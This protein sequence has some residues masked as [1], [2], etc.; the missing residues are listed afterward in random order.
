MLKKVVVV[1]VVLTLGPAVAQTP[2]VVKHVDVYKEDGH[3]AGWPA[4]NGIWAWGDE[5]VVGFSLGYYK[6]HPTGGHAID[7]DRRLGVRQARSLDG[8]ETWS[9]ERPSY[10]GEEGQEPQPVE[11]TGGIDFSNPGFAMRFR[12]D[13]YYYS[14][15]RCKTWEGPFS[16]PKFGRPGLLARTDYLVEDKDT[17]TAFV[18]ATKDNGNE[19]QPLCIRT[20]DGGKTWDLVG[21]IGQQPPEGY[22]YAI[23]PSTIRLDSGAYLSMIR[24]AGVFDGTSRR[25]LEAFLS[26]DR[27]STWYMLDEP[28]IDNG[29]NPAS[30]INLQDGRIVLT[31]GWRRPPR[32]IR[33]LVSED[34]GQTWGPEI[35]LRHDAASWDIGYPR[36]VQ[37]TDG[38]CLT[39][40]YYHHPDQPERYIACTIWD[41]GE[42]SDS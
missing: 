40:Y 25:W 26:P 2:E 20:T 39:I 27:G 22:G 16:L 4:N 28:R 41:A 36:T 32:G 33:A 3:F 13:R 29:G 23:M 12:Q 37:R 38:K 11:P 7:P 21:W 1:A 34:H 17:L 24:R 6:E 42:R 35:V 10:V 18:A 19:G 31:Y 8:G 15:D 30:M 5:I 14:L 9:I